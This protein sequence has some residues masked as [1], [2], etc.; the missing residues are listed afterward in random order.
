MF[1]QDSC[2][3]CQRLKDHVKT[4]TEDELRLNIM[5]NYHICISRTQNSQRRAILN[6][7]QSMSYAALAEEF[8]VELSPTL[9]VAYEA[10][11]CEYDRETG[12]EYCDLEE[13]PVEIQ[14][15]C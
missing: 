14:V 12:Y 1:F 11:S 2:P 13:E 7:M 4:L 15:G 10:K 5:K 8:A 9:V 3:P 6:G